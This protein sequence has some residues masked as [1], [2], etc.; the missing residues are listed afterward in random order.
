MTRQTSWRDVV[1]EERELIT[2]QRGDRATPGSFAESG[3]FFGIAL[4]GGGVR[5]ATVCLGFLQIL[6]RCGVLQQADYLSSVSGGGYIGGYLHSRLHCAATNSTLPALFDKRDQDLLRKGTRYLTPGAGLTYSLS[7]LR[8]IT[9][10]GAS[11]LLNSIWILASFACFTLVLAVFWKLMPALGSIVRV[12]LIGGTAL[13]LFYHLVGHSLRHLIPWS[14]DRLIAIEAFLV[15]IAAIYAPRFID[16]LEPLGVGAILG[17][18][19][20]A[21][22]I[23]AVVGF[24][25]NPNVLGLHRFYRDRL[26]DTYLAT[27]AP[28]ARD[29]RLH[30]LWTEN[31]QRSSAPYPLI[32]TCVTLLAEP[33]GD[34][35]LGRQAADYFVLSPLYCGSKLTHYAKTDEV[36]SNVKLSTAIATSGAA[37]NPA[38]GIHTRKIRSFLVALLGIRLGFWVRNPHPELKRPRW[39]PGPLARIR[40]PW[41]PYYHVLE[42]VGRT[43]SRRA[44]V[45]LSDGGNIENL[46]VFELIRRR[47]RLIIAVDATADPAYRLTDLNNL[48]LRARHE[49]GVAIDFGGIKPEDIIRPRP[50]AGT[51][52][53]HFVVGRLSDLK[54]KPDEE[55]NW[56]LL[57]YVKSSLR[58]QQR[59]R[60]LKDFR[61]WFKPGHDYKNN[62]PSFPHESTTDQFFDEDQWT[63]YF[64]LGRFIAGDVLQQDV[65][66]KDW[67][68]STHTVRLHDLYE[69]LTK[70]DSFTALNE[71]IS[72]VDKTDS[73]PEGRHY[74]EPPNGK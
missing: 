4:S 71:Y 29:L 53:S 12:V 14:S 27:G 55:E 35:Q 24:F 33:S 20:A 66:R 70:L 38:M 67:W 41:W 16:V 74:E 6:Y 34:S 42:L 13:V 69:R 63:A 3:D 22:L 10:I 61:E 60:A 45:N 51:S 43:D 23:A 9:G 49:L 25:S 47:C 5:S 39:L 18:A 44:F 2:R 26:A 21:A 19:L 15:L 11:V 65:R 37:V 54:G 1:E 30:E 40:F 58:Q 72:P 7:W 36:F 68:E 64:Q 62:H 50:S 8:L 28:A 48:V 46:G 73:E 59:W 17:W 31:P 32:N 57:V 52:R 56:G